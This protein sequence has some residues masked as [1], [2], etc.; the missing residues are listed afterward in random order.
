MTYFSSFDEAWAWFVAGGELRT[1]ASTVED[2]TQG[3]SQFLG[4]LAVVPEAA[5][6]EAELVQDALADIPGLRSLPREFLHITL[7]GAGY[8]VIEKR[9]PDDILRQE[10]PSIG[11]RA[12]PVLRG[13]APV[14][15]TVGP[16]NVFPD[17]VVLEVHDGGRLA[18]IRGG[19]AAEL[20]GGE[21]LAGGPPFLPHITIAVFDDPAVAG[22][23]RELL[24]ALRADPPVEAL[25]RRIELIRAWYTGLE[26]EI[27]ELETVRSYVLRG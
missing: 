24:P 2:A 9:R 6:D 4:F 18:E 22:A 15:L 8:Q 10:V 20:G 11:E 7:L 5:S 26:A 13:A 19:L 16:V 14:A 1:F 25:V 27:P 17:A 21:R 23:L 12:G 3:R